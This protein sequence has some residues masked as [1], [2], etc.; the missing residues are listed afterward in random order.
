MERN[1]RSIIE[2]HL[3]NLSASVALASHSIVRPGV[4]ATDMK[5]DFYRLLYVAK[6]GGWLELNGRHIETYAGM[7]L[8]LPAGASQSYGITGEENLEIYWCH[9]YA[10][11]GDV[12]LFEALELPIAVVLKEPDEIVQ[13][14]ERMVSA[15]NSDSICG[16]LR[17]K[18]ALF[19]GLACFL[20]AC[21]LDE[22]SLGEVDLLSKLSDV[23]GYIDEHLADNISLED[24][25]RV[26]YVHPNYFIG[27]FKSVIGMSPIQY[28]NTRRLE[29]AKRLLA[30][31]D[32]NV[33]HIAAI[34]GMQIHYL[35]RLFKQ[36]T[37]V[38]PKRYRQLQR[39]MAMGADN[40]EPEPEGPG[41]NPEFIGAVKGG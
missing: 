21:C 14:F 1:Y 27:L 15:Y 24:L 37:G 34:V 9:F 10:N 28:V 20:D 16:G 36:Y 2:N 23:V 31:T 32:E 18:A 30:E 33:T 22:K 6:G 25:A 7:L 5:P 41:A 17:V 35:S 29:T 11:L 8:L 40:A 13:V 26:A 4:V 19:E 39:E 38:S 3:N 12:E